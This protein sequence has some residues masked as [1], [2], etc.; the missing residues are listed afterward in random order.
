MLLICGTSFCFESN[1]SHFIAWMRVP[2]EHQLLFA[3]DASYA[4]RSRL[5]ITRCSFSLVSWQ[6]EFPLDA[7]PGRP[8]RI[9]ACVPSLLLLPF[10]GA[11]ALASMVSCHRGSL[12]LG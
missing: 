7:E 11:S 3:T 12:T 8:S 4:S 5:T 9:R 10:S 6:G 1:V 2:V